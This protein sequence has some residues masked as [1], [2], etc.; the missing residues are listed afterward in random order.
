M[1]GRACWIQLLGREGTTTLGVE[2]KDQETDREAEREGASPFLQIS[3]L[4]LCPFLGGRMR[5]PAGKPEANLQGVPGS[6]VVRLSK[7]LLIWPW[8]QFSPRHIGW[9]LNQ[10]PASSWVPPPKQYSLQSPILGPR[11]WEYRMA[12]LSWEVNSLITDRKVCRQEG[13]LMAA[14]ETKSA[15]L[16]EERGSTLGTRQG[17]QNRASSHCPLTWHFVL[18][19][20][21][22]LQIEPRNCDS[23]REDGK[24][25]GGCCRFLW[26]SFFK[27]SGSFYNGKFQCTSKVHRI[28]QEL[29]CSQ[30]ATITIIIVRLHVL[31]ILLYPSPCPSLPIEL[32]N[33]IHDNSVHLAYSLTY[34]Q[35]EHAYV[36]P[37]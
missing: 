7:L 19:V 8:V 33:F 26:M 27:K 5:R 28:V 1:W 29:P 3:H 13:E 34:S 35:I 16:R 15:S 31:L 36:S 18:S 37:T 11:E 30:L 17:V 21:I 4:P 10:D 9:G 12:G 22:Y 2:L 25:P 6:P 23:V 32:Y 24:P 14:V 20:F